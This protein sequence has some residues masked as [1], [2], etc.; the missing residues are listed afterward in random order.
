MAKNCEYLSDIFTRTFEE[1]LTGFKSEK[2]KNNYRNLVNSLC[3]YAEKD[4]LDL[5]KS[6]LQGYFG[7]IHS[8]SPDTRRQRL[9]TFKG[10]AQYMDRA[11][12]TKLEEIFNGI[13]T[14]ETTL[15][16]ELKELP[17]YE[18]IDKVLGVLKELDDSNTFA[19]LALAAETGL[20][21][22]DILSLKYNNFFTDKNGSP[23]IR[24]EPKVKGALTRNIP[25]TEK[26][27][28][29]IDSIGRSH[30]DSKADDYIFKNTKGDPL[31]E[32]MVQ[33]HI[34]AACKKAG[35]EVFG[36]NKVRTLAM[37]VMMKGGASIKALS[38]ALDETGTWFFR[39]N[40]VVHDLPTAAASYNHIKVEW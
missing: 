10:V 36:I 8:K 19:I 13:N 2:S 21:T 22:G 39:L 3:S 28:K 38:Y 24:I 26:T 9:S 16:T 7:K 6:D 34:N 11:L 12:G 18:D 4:F 17:D 25:L 33:L 20:N 40:H 5:E 31:S 32:R 15:Y 27:S 23:L 14:G 1:M 35:V 29:L 30:P 37:A